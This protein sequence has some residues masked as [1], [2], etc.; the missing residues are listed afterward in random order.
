[1][2]CVLR[3][4]FTNGQLDMLKIKMNDKFRPYEQNLAIELFEDMITSDPSKRATTKSIL[5]HP[6]W[7]QE[8]KISNFFQ[9]LSDLVE[10]KNVSHDSLNM[11]ER[12]APNIIES[13]WKEKLDEI[14]IKAW[15]RRYEGDKVRHLVRAIRNTVSCPVVQMHR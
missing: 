6:L 12:D 4:V 10:G 7:W 8:E 14:L 13:C 5:K 3:Y 15:R 9:D 11:L 1:M 2:G